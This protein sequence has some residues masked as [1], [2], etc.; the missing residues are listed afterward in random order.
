MITLGLVFGITGAIAALPIKR[1]VPLSS[2]ATGAGQQGE[3][4]RPGSTDWSFLGRRPMVAGSV[5]VLLTGMGIFIPTLWIP[6]QHR[7][8]AALE[9]EG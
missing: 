8:L 9:H 4:R 5:V 2:Y 6:S 1:R 3:R 7:D